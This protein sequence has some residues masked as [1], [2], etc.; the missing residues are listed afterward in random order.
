MVI[1][2]SLIVV[3]TNVSKLAPVSDYKYQVLVGDG[4]A[5]GS[6]TIAAGE[7]KGHKRED[8]W[9]ALVHKLLEREV[10]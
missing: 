1:G 10:K 2:M 9:Q 8:G 6:N 3:I 5:E 4:T 7:I